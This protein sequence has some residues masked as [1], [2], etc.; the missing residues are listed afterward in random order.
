MILMQ[1]LLWGW[2]E[3]GFL[4][5]WSKVGPAINAGCIFCFT[6]GSGEPHFAQD[7]L[8]TFAL[9]I[10]FLWVLVVLHEPF[11]EAPTSQMSME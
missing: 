9:M 6:G 4:H 5:G 1:V 8:W 2:W 10:F 3:G 11:G 7:L